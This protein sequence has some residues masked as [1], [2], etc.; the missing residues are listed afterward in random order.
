MHCADGEHFFCTG[1]FLRNAIVV[2]RRKCA[3][4]EGA[5]NSPSR[6]H[7][8][9]CVDVC[10]VPVPFPRFLSYVSRV[11]CVVCSCELNEKSTV[12]EWWVLEFAARDLRIDG[13]NNE[14]LATKD[15]KACKQL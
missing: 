15:M 6:V 1:S 11:V 2:S 4:Y 10:F 3:Y 13:R 5:A 9:M 12:C 7:A 14:T 8:C